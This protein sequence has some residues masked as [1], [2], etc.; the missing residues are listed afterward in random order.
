[1][2]ALQDGLLDFETNIG[3]FGFKQRSK[4]AWNEKALRDH[5][6]RIR[7]QAVA[8]G[9]LLQVIRL[10]TSIDR[11]QQVKSQEP[12][13]RKYDE[14]AYSIIP[15]CRSSGVFSDRMS[16]DSLGTINRRHT[17]ENDLYN[18]RVYKR[19]Y[20]TLFMRSISQKKPDDGLEER[21]LPSNESSKAVEKSDEFSI[22]RDVPAPKSYMI[23]DPAH[24]ARFDESPDLIRSSTDLPLYFEK[25]PSDIAS[26]EGRETLSIAVR[27][28]D[29][30]SEEGPSKD[31]V[32]TD[33]SLPD[34]SLLRISAAS[35][36]HTVSRSRLEMGADPFSKSSNGQQYIDMAGSSGSAGLVD[37]LL[38]LRTTLGRR[39]SQ[40]QPLQGAA[41]FPGQCTFIELGTANGINIDTW[42]DSGGITLQIACHGQNFGNVRTFLALAAESLPSGIPVGTL[43]RVPIKPGLLKLLLEFLTHNPSACCRRGEMTNPMLLPPLDIHLTAYGQ[44]ILAL[45]KDLESDFT[46]KENSGNQ[47]LHHLSLRAR[48][49]G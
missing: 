21:L 40:E 17:F 7:G 48:P 11:G 34:P 42:D 31:S 22:P 41:A 27:S 30:D 12:K 13:F 9:L 38:N 33:T 8:M 5:Q 44:R 36:D 25:I 49:G 18:A 26:S 35:E 47:V 3:R 39:Q 2:S 23:D 14:S 32:A 1:M 37:T 15:S 46:A 43:E 28:G 29:I 16:V 45:C 10:P 4:A 6:D 20:K 24:A 19:N